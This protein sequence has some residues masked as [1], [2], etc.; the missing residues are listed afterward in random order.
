MHAARL[1]DV[2]DELRVEARALSRAARGFVYSF[3]VSVGGVALLSGQAA[4]IIPEDA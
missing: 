1:D 2:A 4:I 3:E